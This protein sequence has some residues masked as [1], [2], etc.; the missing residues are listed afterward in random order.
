MSKKHAEILEKIHAFENRI[1]PAYKEFVP[2]VEV[3]GT[4][5]FCIFCYAHMSDDKATCTYGLRHEFFVKVEKPKP[6]VVV[7]KRLCIKCR[8]HIKNPKSATNGCEHEYEE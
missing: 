7:D 2:I 4:P 6:K 1:P 8:I 5:G 3:V